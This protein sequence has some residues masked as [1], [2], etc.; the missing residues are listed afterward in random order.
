MIFKLFGLFDGD[1]AKFFGALIPWNRFKS[2]RLR[3]NCL[4]VDGHRGSAPPGGVSAK[5]DRPHP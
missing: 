4:I 5:D 2:G 1:G 3:S